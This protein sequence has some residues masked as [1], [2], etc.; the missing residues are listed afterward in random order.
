MGE[1]V[2]F[3][4]AIAE[5]LIEHGFKLVGRSKLAWFFEDSQEIEEYMARHTLLR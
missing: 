2:V 5:E 4:K 1:Y 3:T